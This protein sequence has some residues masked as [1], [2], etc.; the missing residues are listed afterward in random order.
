MSERGIK[1]NTDSKV[2]QQFKDDTNIHKIVQRYQQFG[3][4]PKGAS[5]PIYIDHTQ[6][7]DY[8]TMVN[9]VKTMETN[10]NRLPALVRARFQNQPRNLLD[11]L[12]KAENIEE[13]IDL[14]LLHDK[15]RA[16]IPAG[17]P[18]E[19]VATPKTSA[20]QEGSKTVVPS[21][22]AKE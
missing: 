3:T 4:L 9:K 13:A 1:L 20:P 2:Q 21:E 8:T 7:E 15:A 18:V 22:D 17:S 19:P 5:E 11:F 10:F 16:L 14:G 6:Y 12:G